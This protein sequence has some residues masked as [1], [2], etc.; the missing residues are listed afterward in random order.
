MAFTRGE[1]TAEGP[2]EGW[3]VQV[4]A[5]T[6]RYASTVEY[7]TTV[8]YPSTVRYLY[9]A[10]FLKNVVTEGAFNLYLAHN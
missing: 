3:L 9:S 5:S 10:V 4:R 2:V 7:V 1:V 6:V 8:R